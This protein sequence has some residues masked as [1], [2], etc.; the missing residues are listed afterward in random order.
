MAPSFQFFETFPIKI[1]PRAA[2]VNTH[3][4]HSANLD[5]NILEAWSQGFMVGGLIVLI[6]ITVANMRRHVLLHKLILLELVMALGHGTF[7]FTPDP[8]Y[9]WHLSGTAIFLYL[10]WY[11]HNIVAWMKN[12]P[13]L[14]RWG[15]L[16]YICSVIFVFP[17]WIAEMYLNF[18]YFNAL[19]DDHFNNTRP[20]EALA[21]DPWWIFTTCDLIYIIKREYNF[22]LF[23]LIRASPRF[24]VLIL[25]MFLSIVFLVTDVAVTAAHVGGP[26]GI[27]PYWKLALV[28]KCAA[29]ALFLD[30]FKKVLDVLIT[31][32]LGKM[33]GAVHGG[34]TDACTNVNNLPQ[35]RYRSSGIQAAIT[36]QP[37]RSAEPKRKHAVFS[38]KQAAPPQEQKSAEHTVFTMPQFEPKLT[39]SEESFRSDDRYSGRTPPVDWSKTSEDGPVPVVAEMEDSNSTALT[40]RRPVS[41]MSKPADSP[42]ASGSGSG[43]MDLVTT[44]I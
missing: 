36:G 8:A 41:P 31:H 33:G 44:A 2:R 39:R 21:R 19:G 43:S 37:R 38:Y 18:Q 20:W 22:G 32:T 3:G 6:M 23:E 10:S 28:F 25:S 34:S 30:D 7:I 1:Q 11:L 4:R 40:N 5:E 13:F 15:S 12:K 42:V 9:G 24:G 35:N 14:P 29:D 26:S 17:Y 16:L 27:N